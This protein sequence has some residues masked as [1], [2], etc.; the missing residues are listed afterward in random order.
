MWMVVRDPAS[1]C[2]GGLMRHISQKAHGLRVMGKEM[3]SSTE[4][5]SSQKDLSPANGTHIGP[6]LCLHLSPKLQPQRV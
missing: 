2:D 4:R 3:G 5:A 6:P 1:D